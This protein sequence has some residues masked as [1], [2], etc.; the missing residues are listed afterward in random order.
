MVKV[1][2]RTPNDD[3]SDSMNPNNDAWQDNADNRS[4]QLNPNNHSYWSSRDNSSDDDYSDYGA[5]PDSES[6]QKFIS[7]SEEE[8]SVGKI[9]KASKDAEKKLYELE[10]PDLIIGK[11]ISINE[12]IFLNS[13]NPL[14]GRVESFDANGYLISLRNSYGTLKHV[15]HIHI[16]AY[17][18]E[19]PI[20]L[21]PALV[22]SPRKLGIPVVFV[23][24][25]IQTRGTLH[26]TTLADDAI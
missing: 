25:G 4:N 22:G 13:I 8:I 23:F 17:G 21:A 9:L 14:I 11:L 20:S 7:L 16:M 5:M 18:A 26:I 24:Y 15:P 12:I 3:R 1:M 2:S 10:N 19:C 6:R